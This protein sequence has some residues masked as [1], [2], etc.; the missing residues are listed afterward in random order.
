LH[1][2]DAQRSGALRAL[3]QELGRLHAH[4]VTE[5]D[6]LKSAMQHPSANLLMRERNLPEAEPCENGQLELSLRNRWNFCTLLQLTFAAAVTLSLLAALH[7]LC[8]SNPS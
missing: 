8:T 1:G 7:Q 2:G 5:L 4:R 6:R 3:Q